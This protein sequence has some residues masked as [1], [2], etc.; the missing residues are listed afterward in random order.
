MPTVTSDFLPALFTEFQVMFEDEFFAAL[1][2]NDYTRIASVM[3]SNTLTESINWLGTVPQMRLWTDER[4][5]QAIAPS[6]TYSVTNNHYEATIDVDRDTIE[7][8]RY[9]LIMPRIGQLG[10][11]AG[12]Y[13]WVLAINALVANGTGYDGQSFFSSSHVSGLSGTQNNTVSATGQTLA[14]VTTDLT[15]AITQIRRFKDD[16]GRPMNLGQPKTGTGGPGGLTILAPPELESVFRQLLNADFLPAAGVAAP[17]SNWFKG[18][19]DLIVDP[20]LTSA[21]A[22]YLLDLGHSLKPLIYLDRK[23]PEFVPMDD[24]KNAQVFNKRQFSYGVDF[25]GNVGYGLWQMAVKVS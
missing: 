7:D 4:V 24:P 2:V 1:N 21:T 15:S 17:Q 20:Y 6:Y 13:P 23:A 18:Y 8:D 3:K 10:Q 22:W 25:R 16:Q 11:E 19:A 14:A 9:R 12:R 5:H